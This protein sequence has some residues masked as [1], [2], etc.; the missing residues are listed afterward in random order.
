MYAIRPGTPQVDIKCDVVEPSTPLKW[1]LE[2]EA[3]ERIDLATVDHATQSVVCAI[4]AKLCLTLQFLQETFDKLSWLPEASGP[5]TT[6]TLTVKDFTK[7]L[8]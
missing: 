5:V 1:F 7:E 8:V 4:L 6:F 3:K 2:T